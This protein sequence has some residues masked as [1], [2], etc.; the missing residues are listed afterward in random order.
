MEPNYNLPPQNAEQQPANPYAGIE[1]L[2]QSPEAAPERM[3]NVER[4]PNLN[5]PAAAIPQL[6]MPVV[7]PEPVRPNDDATLGAGANPQVAADDDLIEKEWVERAKRI[8]EETRDDP[9]KREQAVVQL[10][11]DYLLKRYG[12]ELGSSV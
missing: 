11:K 12:K 7:A 6:P 8:I 3:P 4:A 1:Q 2:G 10:Q 5:E 9:R